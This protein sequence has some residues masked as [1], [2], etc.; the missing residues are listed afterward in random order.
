MESEYD[1]NKAL[2]CPSLKLPIPGE[3]KA[4]AMPGR[5]YIHTMNNK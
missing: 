3:A 4:K 2:V 5:L 1:E